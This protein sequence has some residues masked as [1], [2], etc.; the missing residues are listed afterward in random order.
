MNHL[1][2]V[3]LYKIL[4]FANSHH[5]NTVHSAKL[6][7]PLI[8]RSVFECDEVCGNL[9]GRWPTPSYKHSVDNVFQMD[10]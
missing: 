10:K 2:L 8:V 9:F 1:L 3:S 6:V 5:P 4:H 7:E